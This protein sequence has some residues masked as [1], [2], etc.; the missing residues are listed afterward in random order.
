MT[1]DWLLT[2][3]WLTADWLLADWQRFELERFGIS[4]LDNGWT[5]K[6]TSAFLW[7]LLEPKNISRLWK[8][9]NLRLSEEEFLRIAEINISALNSATANIPAD[10]VTLIT[11]VLPPN[12]QRNPILQLRMHLCWGNWH[13]PHHRDIPIEKIFKVC[14]FRKC[15]C[16]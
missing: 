12:Y 14:S 9:F 6:Q 7:F 3:C 8:N 16:V 4:A 2:D 5:D 13:G 11:L 10:K 15:T 1:A